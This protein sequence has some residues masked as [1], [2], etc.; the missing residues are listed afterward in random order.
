MTRHRRPFAQIGTALRV[1]AVVFAVIALYPA[2]GMVLVRMG[3]IEK[4]EQ[5]DLT[6]GNAHATDGSRAGVV[7][8]E[9]QRGLTFDHQ[10]LLELGRTV[11]A[12]ATER[13]GLPSSPEW[14]VDVLDETSMPAGTRLL[15]AVEVRPECPGRNT[16]ATALRLWM[17]A[18]FTTDATA[19]ISVS[20][21]RG[22]T[23]RPQRGWAQSFAR[24]DSQWLR[25]ERA[26]P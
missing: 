17:V 2:G 7:L 5:Q 19:E 16:C 8:D 25:T 10:D 3:L 26:S 12:D 6:I 21:A 1:T 22:H 11:A 23:N 24:E 20:Y 14:R 18:A 4:P 15:T 9:A 13:L